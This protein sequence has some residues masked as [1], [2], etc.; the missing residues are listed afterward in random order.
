M[1]NKHKSSDEAH[2][3]PLQQCNV[4]GSA[5]RFKSYEHGKVNK[6][7]WKYFGTNFKP[8]FLGFIFNKQEILIDLV[9]F[10]EYLEKT[11]NYEGSMEEFVLHRFGGNAHNF[12]KKLI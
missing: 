1:E 8:F 6:L 2:S 12:I 7:F 4:V 9:K 3:E 10:D 11:Y 5:F